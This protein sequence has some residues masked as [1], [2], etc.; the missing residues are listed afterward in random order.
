MFNRAAPNITTLEDMKK[1]MRFNEFHTDKEAGWPQRSGENAIA[2]RSDL[3]PP[4]KYI[5]PAL[6]PR[7]HGATDAKITSSVLM[8]NKQEF[9][10]VSGPTHGGRDN[11]PVFSWDAPTAPCASFAHHGNP[12]SF[13][14]DWITV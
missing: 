8:N 11:L 1:I 5:F 7:C 14:F 2:A 6:G 4:G 9:V 12:T 10:A 13:D 3:N